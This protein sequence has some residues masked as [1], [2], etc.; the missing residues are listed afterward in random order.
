M[1]SSTL[2]LFFTCAT[3]CLYASLAFPLDDLDALDTER[4]ERELAAAADPGNMSPSG[5]DAQYFFALLYAACNR[6]C[7][8]LLLRSYNSS[9]MLFQQAL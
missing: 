3:C 4:L 1:Q 6:T 8:R 7:D 2:S 5:S 9:L